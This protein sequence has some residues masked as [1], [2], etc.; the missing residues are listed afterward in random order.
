MKKILIVIIILSTLL[1][2]GCTSQS[3]G[4]TPSGTGTMPQAQAT[5]PVN[6]NTLPMNGH[7]IIG[8]GN[9]TLDVSVDS[10]EVGSVYD[11]GNRDIT[12]YIAAINTGTEPERMVWFSKLTDS[13]GKSYGGIGISHAGSGARSGWILPNITE[14][15][16][17][18]VTIHSDLDLAGLS[19]GAVLDV[20]FMEKPSDDIPV[21]MVPDYHVSWIIDPGTIH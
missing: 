19:K 15:A 10:F 16:R 5:L 7:T 12:V 3:S 13:K 11:N 20:Y 6:K 14:A 9:R 8:S 2:A 21:S 1:A 4:T 17:D 18:Y